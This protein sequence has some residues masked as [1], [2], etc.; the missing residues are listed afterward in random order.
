MLDRK[1]VLDEAAAKIEL[2]YA[3]TP[4][5]YHGFITLIA[6]NKRLNPEE[7]NREAIYVRVET[8]YIRVDGRVAM[9]RDDHRNL[10]K[11][12]DIMKPVFDAVFDIPTCQVTVFSEVYGTATGTSKVNI[13]GTGVDKTSPLENAET[14]AIGRA[15]GFMGYGLLGGGIASAEEVEQAMSE[16]EPQGQAP[17]PAPRSTKVAEA[18]AYALEAKPEKGSIIKIKDVPVAPSDK[19]MQ[20]LRGLL[21]AGGT[22]KGDSLP[23][24]HAVYEH[25]PMSKDRISADIEELDNAD[26]LTPKYL[27][28]YLKILRERAK[29]NHGDVYGYMEKYFGVKKIK[30]LTRAQQ[31]QLIAWMAVGQEHGEAWVE[32]VKNTATRSRVDTQ[33]VSDWAEHVFPD[34]SEEDVVRR[35]AE[36]SDKD[37]RMDIRTY[38][39]TMEQQLEMEGVS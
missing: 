32:M 19:Q 14:S 25:E 33:T 12:L 3:T 13:G 10:G 30:D 37:L 26:M 18:D 16:Q 5:E 21:S 35:V 24:I 36:I 4:P 2:A 7:R 29:L 20:F 27:G 38:Q 17:A 28:A 31:D 9:A 22:L 34:T 1:Q 15:L 23:V 6:Q 11:R 8:P 39:R